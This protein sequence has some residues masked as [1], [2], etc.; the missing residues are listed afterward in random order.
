MQINPIQQ[1]NQVNFTSTVSIRNCSEVL[2]S[3]NVRA[4]ILRL[5]K[6]GIDDY[7]SIKTFQSGPRD[8]F[9]NMKVMNYNTGEEREDN[10]FFQNG[11]VKLG[12]FYKKLLK[13]KP[14]DVWR[15]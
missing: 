14:T 6:N 9:I 5:E 2:R 10:F 1:N 15:F 7:V 12:L 8:G 3:K 13:E 11:K 4:Q